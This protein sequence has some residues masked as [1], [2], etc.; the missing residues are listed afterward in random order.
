[1]LVGIPE[2]TSVDTLEVELDSFG[3]VEVNLLKTLAADVEGVEVVVEGERVDF[4]EEAA[5]DETE[6]VK[7]DGV[8][9]VLEVDVPDGAE[10]EDLEGEEVD[11]LEGNCSDELDVILEDGEVDTASL[12]EVCSLEGVDELKV[13]VNEEVALDVDKGVEVD[14]VEVVLANSCVDTLVGVV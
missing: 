7:V 12:V 1:M 13:S 8:L 5:V 2:K 6:L 11:P 9:E 4:I 3:E 10:V 14:I